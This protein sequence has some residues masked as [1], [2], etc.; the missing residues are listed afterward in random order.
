MGVPEGRRGERPARNDPALA[1]LT[2]E[3]RPIRGLYSVAPP[4]DTPVTGHTDSSGGAGD[5]V[6]EPL[7][8]PTPAS[9]VPREDEGIRHS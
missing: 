3:K 4:T 5:V 2:Q 9:G 6:V 7:I 1:V 8:R